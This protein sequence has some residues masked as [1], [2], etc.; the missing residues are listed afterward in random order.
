[1]NRFT[2]DREPDVPITTVDRA[3]E[4]D[5]ARRLAELRDRRDAAAVDTALAEVGRTAHGEGNLLYPMKD[6]LRLGATLGEVSK[7]LAAVF[8]RYRPNR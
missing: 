4:R 7:V 1:V 3:L 2:D 5:Q 6:A 8:G